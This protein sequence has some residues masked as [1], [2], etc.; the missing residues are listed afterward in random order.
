[1]RDRN[2][3]MVLDIGANEGQ[4]GKSLRDTIGFKGRMVSF[5][6]LH[7]AFGLLKQTIAGDPLWECHNIA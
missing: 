6:P 1:M 4:Y 7:D 3:N 5:E 2:I